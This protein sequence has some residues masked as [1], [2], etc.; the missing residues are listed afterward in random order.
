MDVVGTVTSTCEV[1]VVQRG[2]LRLKGLLSINQ[3]SFLNLAI[4]DKYKLIT[5]IL[6]MSSMTLVSTGHLCGVLACP[7]IF[8]IMQLVGGEMNQ[9][10]TMENPWIIV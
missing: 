10:K 2:V 8:P 5:A 3:L 4:C 7:D 1:L 9:S 6:I